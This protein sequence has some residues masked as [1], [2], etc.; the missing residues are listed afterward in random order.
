MLSFSFDL[1]E[2][3]ESGNIVLSGFTI[4]ISLSIESL[5]L[6][7]VSIVSTIF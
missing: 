6:E 1:A 4:F 3:V 7:S 2:V 5:N